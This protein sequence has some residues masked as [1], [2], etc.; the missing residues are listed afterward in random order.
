[1]EIDD[2][3][4]LKM[5]RALKAL[6]GLDVHDMNYLMQRE[7]ARKQK[8]QD[9]L[10]EPRVAASATELKTKKTHHKADNLE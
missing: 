10:W 2:K 5:T 6:K 9:K 3:W 8:E 7:L 4:V 1:M